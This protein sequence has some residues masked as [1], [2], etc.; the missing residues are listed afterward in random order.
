MINLLRVYLQRIHEIDLC[1]CKNI[2]RQLL[3]QGLTQ[4]ASSTFTPSAS[5]LL[6]NQVLPKQIL[7]H[8]SGHYGVLL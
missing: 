3:A 7:E 5:L 6:R 4:L 8:V 2:I 1:S